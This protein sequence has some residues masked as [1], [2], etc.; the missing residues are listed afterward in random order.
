M[1]VTGAP[2]SHIVVDVFR[3][4]LAHVGL[5]GEAGERVLDQVMAERRKAG[6]VDCS[7]R[8][9]AHAGEIVITLTQAGRDWK[10]SAPVPV[11]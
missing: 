6:S 9:A 11:R 2:D 10:M 3:C 7:L 4:V 8:F 5:K 1:T